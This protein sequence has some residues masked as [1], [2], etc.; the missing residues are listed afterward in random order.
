LNLYEPG[1][2]LYGLPP[3]M[4]GITILY[5]LKL[6]RRAVVVSSTYLWQQAVE[7]LRV[8]SPFQKLRMNL[9]LFLQLLIAALILLTLARPRSSAGVL[10]ARDVVLVID[11][12]ASMGARD[13]PDGPTRLERALKEARRLV[14]DMASNDRGIVIA[15]DDKPETLQRMTSSR[16]LIGEALDGIEVRARPTSMSSAVELAFNQSRADSQGRA[17]VVFLFS[18]GRARELGRVYTEEEIRRGDQRDEGGSLEVRVP[19]G[20][21]LAYVRLG[22][23]SPNV[24]IANIDLQRTFDREG[25]LQL[26]VGVAN[27]SSEGGEIGL[28][29]SLEGEL[30]ESQI[31]KLGPR[32]VTSVVVDSEALKAGR[33]EVKL[34]L[35]GRRDALDLDDTGYL[36]ARPREELSV[37]LVSEGNPFLQ[38]ALKSMHFVRVATISPGLFDP[39]APESGAYDAI[40]LDRFMPSAMP[41]A[42]CF[43]IDVLPP[44]KELAWG[45]R[46]VAPRIVDWNETHP[47]SAYVDFTNLEPAEMRRVKLRKRD[48]SI[49]DGEG[50]SMVAV[51]REGGRE[52][53]LL[54]FNPLRSRWPFQAGF[55]I[56]IANVVRW[57]GGKG[58]SGHRLHPGDRVILPLGAGSTKVVVT[59]PKGKSSELEVPEGRRA[60]A[61]AE[62]NLQGFY[63][64]Q[65]FIGG[66]PSRTIPFA[67]NLADG[68]EGDLRPRPKLAVRAGSDAIKG[69][70]K[71]QESNREIWRLIAWACL[72]VL[73]FEWW[74]YNR[75][76]F[77]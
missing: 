70:T 21:E 20:V 27:N 12:S 65:I 5:F 36:I 37:L 47:I 56:F 59:N 32:Q 3:M 16:R 35:K 71:I 38:R 57:L 24:G 46:L 9:L 61:F 1:W 40:I 26:F 19:D 14:N 34:D 69:Q 43:L 75:K 41:P 7:D 74:V 68:F 22:E 15:F 51:L 6:K 58:S 25:F 45:K 17:R 76:V 77:V 13:E 23:D 42:P 8:N 30:I 54:A 62:T 31:V 2:L 60:V 64:A 33:I 55:P 52:D 10:G 63:S 48:E 72:I 29:V 73:V 11:R 28:D 50:G 44:Y 66:E 4:V 18:D 49:V 53:V 67:V 39:K